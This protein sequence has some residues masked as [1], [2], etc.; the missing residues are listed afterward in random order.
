MDFLKRMYRKRKY[1][2]PIVVVSG[3][4]RS[5]TSMMMSMLDAGGME[6]L[7][8]HVR[9]ADE[10][11]PKGYYEFEPIK[12]LGR[13]KE[14]AW[15]KDARGKGVK[16]VSDLLKELSPDY[17][18]HV[19]FMNRNLEEVIASQNKMLIR[20]G[21]PAQQ[22]DDEKMRRLFEKHLY[23]VKN[24]VEQQPNFKVVFVDY[25]R[26]LQD[27]LRQAEQIQTFLDRPLD[28]SEMTR[29]VDPHLHRNR[30]VG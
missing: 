17:W 29:V 23:Q 22:G 12:K 19:I 4:P 18:F 2:D 3:L 5:G 27:P 16:V 15:L 26:A 24:W 28:V 13:N 9:E 6:L 1:G 21:E 8:D 30:E 10:D 11:N 25:E 20:R 14:Q 7:T